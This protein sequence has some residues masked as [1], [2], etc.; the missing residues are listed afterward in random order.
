MTTLREAAQ[1]ALEA[2]DNFNRTSSEAYL[3]GF[4]TEIAALRGALDADS[5]PRKPLTEQE[6]DI[7]YGVWRQ[8][9]DAVRKYKE[10]QAI[11]LYTSPPQRKPLTDEE[12]A[13]LMADI[14]GSASI[15]PQSAS[16]F[17]RAIER[18]HGIWGEV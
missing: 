5:K 7:P 6:P 12:I 17:A 3:Y 14:W 4:H 8:G 9:F 16:A 2:L 18:A 11:T 13:T 10:E 1:M 15:S